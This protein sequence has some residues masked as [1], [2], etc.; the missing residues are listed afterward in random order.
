MDFTAYKII[1]VVICIS[2]IASCSSNITK[3][4]QGPLVIFPPPPDTTRIQFL[5]TINSSED[6]VPPVSGFEKFFSGSP[7]PIIINKPFGI[8]VIKDKIFVVDSKLGSICVMDLKKNTFENFIPDGFGKLR[9]PLNCFA[10]KDGYL[11]VADIGRK[12]IVVFDPELK[13]YKSFGVNFFERPIDV[14]VNGNRIVVADMNLKK[15]CVFSRDS[16]KLLS[17]FPDVPEED[18]SF[19]HQPTHI[20]LKNDTIYVTDFGEFHIKKFDLAGN[21]LG[22]VGS[23]G[24]G[25]GQFQRPKGLAIDNESNLYAI[26]AAFENV[27]VFNSEGRILMFFGGA[28]QGPGYLYLPIRIAIDYDNLD[29]FKNYVDEHFN[30]KYLIY[31]TN[32]FGPDK[33]T[34]YGFVVPKE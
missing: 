11:Y 15:L 7:N 29:Y 19:I 32:Q 8:S 3:T 14:A 6:I 34:V 20:L 16:M 1:F 13:F 5:T 21:F 17:S 22:T 10:D 9:N 25:F 31:V 4:R 33:I 27:Q 23:Y 18:T 12:D 30:L 26:D 28:Y 2:L 24:N